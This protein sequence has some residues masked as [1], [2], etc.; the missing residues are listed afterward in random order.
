MC[1]FFC[2]LIFFIYG[3]YFDYKP[4]FPSSQASKTLKIESAM[5][6]STW[7]ITYSSFRPTG[8]FFRADLPPKTT[9]LSPK[10]ILFDFI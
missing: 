10:L 6:K 9:V 4:S 1:V 2:F 5:S 7:G 3:Q 8:T